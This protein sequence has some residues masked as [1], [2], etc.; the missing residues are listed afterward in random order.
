MGL[1]HPRFDWGKIKLKP[2]ASR[3]S[4]THFCDVITSKDVA[5]KATI[6]DNPELQ[7]LCQAINHAKQYDRPIIFFLGGHVI[8]RGCSWLVNQLIKKGFTTHVAT[9]GSCVVHDFELSV[10]RRTSEDVGKHIKTGQF[11]LWSETS[12]INDIINDTSCDSCVGIGKQIGRELRDLTDSIFG[13]AYANNVQATVHPLFGGDINHVHPNFDGAKWGH[14]AHVDLD[15]FTSNVAKLEGGVFCCIGCSVTAPEVY[16]KALS[17][18]RNVAFG[19]PKDFTTAVFDIVE[20]PNNWRHIVPN[21]NNPL[22]YFRPW[23][24]ILIRTIEDGGQSFY[25]QGDHRNTLSSLYSILC[26]N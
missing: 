9:N 14:L 24:T 20:L 7:K 19:H 16:L 3:G 5:N 12:K 13:T 11:G 22:A 15:V 4:L 10:Y 1:T 8:K 2:L 26:L 6:T 21:Y 25:I 18:A 17:A 23:K